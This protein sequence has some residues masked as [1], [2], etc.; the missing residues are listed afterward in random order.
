VIEIVG[1]IP[2]LEFAP[3]HDADHV[4]DV[5]RFMLVVGDEYGGG[6][7]M[8][9]DAAHFNAQALAHFHVEIGERLVQQQQFRL[10]RKRACERDPLLL[11]ARQFVRE[12]FTGTG[13]PDGLEQLGDAARAISSVCIMQAERDIGG[14]IQM[15][16]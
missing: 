14:D 5:E 11:P 12:F 8:L 9:E 6:M 13:E 3:R 4:G 10:R 15:R 16:E 2:L 1:R 7:L